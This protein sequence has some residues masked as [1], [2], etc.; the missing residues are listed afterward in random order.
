MEW[1]LLAL[2]GAAVWLWIDGLGYREQ[3]L[4]MARAIC[5]QADVQLLDDTVALRRISLAREPGG[6]PMRVRR[7][8]HFEF[9][10][11]GDNRKRGQ[12]GFLGNR[13]ESLWLDGTLMG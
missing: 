2:F 10:D 8:Y 12:I 6:G 11:T 7:V 5:Q 13:R 1:G 9:S 4:A 3:A